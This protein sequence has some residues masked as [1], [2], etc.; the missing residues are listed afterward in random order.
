MTFGK[1]KMAIRGL[2]A[3]QTPKVNCHILSMEDIRYT[4]REGRYSDKQ[5][6]ESS[7]LFTTLV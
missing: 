5:T 2:F 1:K 3:K 6:T 7:H 4:I